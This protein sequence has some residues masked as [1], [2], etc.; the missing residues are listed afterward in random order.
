[1]AHT[2]YFGNV[3]KRINSTLQ[4]GTSAAY[5]VLFKNPTSLDTPVITLKKSGDFDYNYARYKNNYYFVTDKKSLNNDLWEI[6][7]ELDP[8]ATAKEDILNSTQFVSYSNISGG[9]WLPDTR[10]PTMKDVIVGRAASAMNFLF[11]D[12]GFYVLSVLGKN[13]AEIWCCDK[14]QLTSLLANLSSWS[15]RIINDIATGDY[16]LGGSGSFTFDW[17]DVPEALQSL[18]KMNAMTGVAGNAYAD[19]PNCIRSCI[20]VPFFAS[21]FA[22]T[23]DEI[24]LGQ[25]PTGVTTFKCKA[26]PVTSSFTINIP[27]HYTDYRRATC[28]DVYLY[29]PLVGMI[30]LSSDNL[31]QTSAL[32][33]KWSA[34]ASDGCV[35]Y[36]ILADNQVIGTYGGQVSVNYPLGVSQQASAG[37]LINTIIGGAEKQISAGLTAAGGMMSGNMIS[38]AGGLAEG[39]INK[40]ATPYNLINTA[41]TR[42]NTCVGGIGGGAGVGLDTFA[43]CYTVAHGTVIEPSQMAATMGVPTMKPLQLSACSGYC[44]CANAHVA[45]DLDARWITQIDGYLNSGFYIE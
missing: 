22:D 16:P 37:Q 29:L 30:N 15:D 27:W 3:K 39:F 19:A 17:S 23:S 6:S 26:T 11:T 10:I 41:A 18:A 14:G 44:Q 12:G 43:V 45:T 9:A 5:D 1:M 25:F 20:W 38:V 8:L 28:E 21:S 35:C 33:I 42:N 24:Y 40:I 31:A 36:E 2:F 13:G 32:T 7:M 34:T 4:G